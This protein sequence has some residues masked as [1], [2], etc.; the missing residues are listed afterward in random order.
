MI[1]VRG[2][3]IPVLRR[4]V[5]SG[6]AGWIET[7]YTPSARSCCKTAAAD[8]PLATPLVGWPAFGLSPDAAVLY[9]ADGASGI[10]A[11]DP[12]TG[13][14]KAAPPAADPPKSP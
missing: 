8:S 13:R 3:R 9:V 6:A 1:S 14:P 7:G 5:A 2:A 10:W 11:C 12:L 4:N